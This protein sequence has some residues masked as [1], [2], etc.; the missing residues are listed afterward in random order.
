MVSDPL[1]CESFLSIVSSVW[2]CFC[3]TPSVLS[4][5][6]K[7]SDIPTECGS[8]LLKAFA[9]S[10]TTEFSFEGFRE[11]VEVVSGQGGCQINRE[12]DLAR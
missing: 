6:P 3:N 4:A 10:T 12:V 1:R 8:A 7:T 9:A 2:Y 11:A 5:F